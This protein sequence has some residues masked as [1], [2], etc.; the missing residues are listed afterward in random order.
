MFANACETAGPFDPVTC[1]PIRSSGYVEEQ[2]LTTQSTM[3]GTVRV[4]GLTLTT[5]RL[6]SSPADSQVVHEDM[7]TISVKGVGDYALMW[8]PTEECAGDVGYTREDGLL[9]D[10][11]TPEALALA[12]GFAF[13][14]GIVSQ[15]S[16]VRAMW[17]CAERPDV[18]NIELVSP[19]K[20]EVARRD[21][22]INSSCGVC[23]GREQL[24]E[25]VIANARPA[26]QPYLT[27]GDLACIRNEMQRRQHVFAGTGGTH[28]AA[29][30]DANL[31]LLHVAEDL[32]RHNAL[33]KVIGYRLL[34]GKDFNACSAFISSRVSYE[35]AAKAVRAGLSILAA[36]SAPSSLAIALAE[37]HGLTLCG[38]VR[39]HRATVYT[40]P[41]RIT[42]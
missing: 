6:D 14:E 21:V 37:Q 3:P 25:R 1:A 28:G 33:D 19:E 9:A 30:F 27:I 15:M 13:T 20:A 8:T 5:D 10:G 32:G 34:S 40:H 31:R 17:I 12:T 39:D 7:L 41:Q 11:G 36:I 18:V 22:V 24:M 16:D 42:G 26:E 4:S 35:M 38:F 2:R 23:G 29:L